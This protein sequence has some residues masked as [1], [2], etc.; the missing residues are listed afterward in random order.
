MKDTFQIT[1][2][3]R[4]EV[5]FA[6]DH[7]EE[8][9]EWNERENNALMG[10]NIDSVDCVTP[11][12]SEP[13]M[14]YVVLSDSMLDVRLAS[15]PDVLS[16]EEIDSEFEYD[17]LAIEDALKALGATAAEADAL[18]DVLH[19]EGWGG[20]EETMPTACSRRDFT[21]DELTNML[22]WLR[23]HRPVEAK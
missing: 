22:E 7:I 19:V 8:T 15:H 1:K 10:E 4:Y 21:H 14:R 18:T 16:V 12:T 9:D 23:E 13:Y 20:V 6:M 17:Y 5:H 11:E 2:T 3:T